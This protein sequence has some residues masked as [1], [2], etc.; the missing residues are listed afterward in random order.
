MTTAYE[1]FF[2]III[3]LLCTTIL[4]NVLKVIYSTGRVDMFYVIEF[5]LTNTYKYF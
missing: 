1:Y 3:I 5:I 2:C 4:R